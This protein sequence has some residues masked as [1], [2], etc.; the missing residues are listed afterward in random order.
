LLGLIGA[1]GH[2]RNGISLL[3]DGSPA[4]V[5]GTAEGTLPVRVLVERGHARLSIVENDAE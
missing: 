5:L 4:I 3:C 2:L 1:E